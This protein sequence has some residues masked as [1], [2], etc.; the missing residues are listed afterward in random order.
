VSSLFV[1]TYT[2]RTLTL[3]YLFVFRASNVVTQEDGAT[4]KD[5]SDVE[6][7]MEELEDCT[8]G[9]GDR[10]LKLWGLRS[11][12][13]KH[14]YAITGWALSVMPEICRDVA[15]RL[16]GNHRDAIERVVR[17][18]HAFPYSNK[19]P[20]L[21]NKTEDEIADLFW[22]EFKAFQH[23]TAPFDKLN[24]WNSVQALQGK[25]YLWH[26]KYSKPYTIILGEVG[27]WN[28]AM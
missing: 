17:K 19:H 7:D 6:S 13:L 9:L 4:K 11:Q 12:K 5:E 3:A 18:L 8:I 28:W 1:L 21:V 27:C 25:S 14:D 2:H 16:D 22:D 24:R 26:E 23:Q 20:V 15:E 10:L